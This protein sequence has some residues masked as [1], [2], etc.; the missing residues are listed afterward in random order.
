MFY[1]FIDYYFF[2]LWNVENIRVKT[3]IRNGCKGV[4]SQIWYCLLNWSIAVQTCLVK[5]E[6]NKIKERERKSW[7]DDVLSELSSFIHKM[8]ENQKAKFYEIKQL[9][10]IQKGAQIYMI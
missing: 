2:I 4:V 8:E 10:S 1:R 7:K 3:Y 5:C 9:K 6:N